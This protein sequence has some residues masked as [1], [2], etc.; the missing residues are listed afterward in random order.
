MFIGETFLQKS[1]CRVLTGRRHSL[2]ELCG[3]T[4]AVG[5]RQREGGSADDLRDLMDIVSVVNDD[6]DNQSTKITTRAK[7]DKALSF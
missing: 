6:E 1:E 5:T 2:I 4:N 3:P 7:L